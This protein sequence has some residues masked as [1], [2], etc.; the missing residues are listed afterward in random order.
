MKRPGQFSRIIGYTIDG[1]GLRVILRLQMGRP[2]SQLKS[3]RHPY[4]N[5]KDY[6][7]APRKGWFNNDILGR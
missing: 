7:G 5:R 2:I 4:D 3:P 1:R 6:P